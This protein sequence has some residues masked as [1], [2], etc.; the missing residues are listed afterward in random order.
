MQFPVEESK[1]KK[2][3]GDRPPARPMPLPKDD[4]AREAFLAKFMRMTPPA[5]D[6]P[7]DKRRPKSKTKPKK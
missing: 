2:Y 7:V 5:F 6:P 1:P 4:K 3:H